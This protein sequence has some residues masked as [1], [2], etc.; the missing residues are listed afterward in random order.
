METHVHRQVVAAK[1]RDQLEGSNEASSL[2]SRLVLVPCRLGM[3]SRSVALGCSRLRGCHG[4]PIPSDR[5]HATQLPHL[6][7][8]ISDFRLGRL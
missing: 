8:R 2:D 6:L 5:H 3:P 1:R 4:Q 7:E